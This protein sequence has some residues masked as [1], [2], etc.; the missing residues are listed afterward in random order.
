MERDPSGKNPHDPGAKLD[1]SKPVPSLILDDMARALWEVIR[2]ASYGMRKYSA[3]GWLQVEDGVARYTN[4]LYRHLLKETLEGS[5]DQDVLDDSGELILHAA[6]VAWNALARLE[7]MLRE[8]EQ[9]D[10]RQKTT[11]S[12]SISMKGP[13]EA[14]P[15]DHSPQLQLYP[16][17]YLRAPDD[18]CFPQPQPAVPPMKLG[19]DADN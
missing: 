11:L 5:Y 19:N 13:I 8:L 6:M 9:I 1:A 7:L 10:A 3:G 18:R 16:D 4:A 2:V 12:P 15:A 14:R 17:W